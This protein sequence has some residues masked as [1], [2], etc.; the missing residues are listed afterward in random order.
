M[1]LF[2]RLKLFPRSKQVQFNVVVFTRC[3]ETYAKLANTCKMVQVLNVAEKN[4]AAKNI[5]ELLSRG[6]MN[7]REGKSK[8]NKIYEFEHNLF[9]Q[10]VKMVVTSVSGHLLSSDFVGNYKKWQGIN[11]VALFEAPIHKFCSEDYQNIKR[12]LEDE[13]KKS[14]YL[15]IWTDCDREGENIGYEIIQVCQA[16]KPNIGVFRAKFSEITYQSVARALQNLGPPNKNVSDA[17]D[18]RIELDLRIG[19]AFTRFQTLRLQKVFPNSLGQSMISYGSCQFPTLGFIVERYRAIEDFVDEKFWK[20]KVVWEL[21]EEERVEFLWKRHHLFNQTVVQILLEKCLENPEADIVKVQTKN[22]SKWRPL[23]LDTV[24]LEKLASRKLRINAKET[25]KIAEKLYTQ[26][27]ISYPRTETNIFPKELDLNPLVQCQTVDPSWGGFAQRV[28]DEGLNPRQGKKSDQAHPP[29]HPTKYAGNLANENERKLYEFIVRHFLACVSKDAQGYETVAE[30][31]IQEEG[32]VAS[33]LQIVARNYLEVYPYERWSDRSLPLLNQG[34][35]FTPTSITMEEGATCAPQ[36]LSEADLISLMEKHGIGTDATHADH[37]E[38][39][40]ARQYAGVQ[41]DGRFLPCSLGM[42]LVQGYDAMGIALSKPNLR[43]E[44]E[45]DLKRVCDG[46][47][48]PNEVLREQIDRYRQVFVQAMEQVTK[49][50]EALSTFFDEERQEAPAPYPD[51][52]LDGNT[53]YC[54]CPSCNLDIT[55]RRKKDNNGFFF[56]CMGYP[57]CKN[58]IWLPTTVQQVEIDAQTCTACPSH[59]PLVRFKFNPGAYAPFYPDTH[60]C[61]IGG[62]DPNFM[63]LLGIRPLVSQPRNQ[64]NP[65]SNNTRTANESR[66]SSGYASGSQSFASSANSTRSSGVGIPPPRPQAQ[67]RPATSSNTRIVSG[68]S[69]RN[70]RQPAPPAAPAANQSNASSQPYFRQPMPLPQRPEN[71]SDTVIVCNC[72]QDA[73]LLTVRKE[74]PNTGRQFY[75]CAKQQD[76]CNFF[77]WADTP[78]PVPSSSEAGEATFRQPAVRNQPPDGGDSETCCYCDGGREPATIRTT[79]KPG[80]NCGRQFYCC[81]KPREV[82]CKFFEWVDDNGASG[83][84]FDQGPQE[85]F[86]RGGAGSSRGTISSRGRGR[87]RGRGSSNESSATGER[88]TRKCGNCGQE[89]HTRNR[90]PDIE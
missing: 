76:G 68:S 81:G 3:C 26:G 86:G 40:K 59:P 31:Q 72:S 60:R 88:K 34:E 30:I 85:A 19:A 69:N 78:A 17:V 82:Q 52:G 10:A 70:T 33:G 43:A 65:Q 25:M 32:F 14:K 13:T 75:K 55:L 57:Q 23:P 22:K 54:K 5:A 36:L 58:A 2:P 67:P 80:P 84:G 50:D 37:I 41:A 47:R 9:N 77:L 1:L 16:I 28:L 20:L 29:I 6:R 90:C 56:S 18:V 83:G 64:N 15:I 21:N 79:Q 73:M 71:N 48:S 89:G 45:A 49:I 24:E 42:G 63:E 38:T 51:T 66:N 87:G 53:S 62:C 27:Y 44:L 7:R 4:D 8:F 11:P 39:I 61:C 46:E 74:G 12:T 35:Q